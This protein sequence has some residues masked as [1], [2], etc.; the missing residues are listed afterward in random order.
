MGKDESDAEEDEETPAV[1][2]PKT[3]E[4]VTDPGR[5]EPDAGAETTAP[6][7]EDVAAS[8]EDIAKD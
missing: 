3:Q 1:E 6:E 7:A 8:V 5:I 4:T 2:S